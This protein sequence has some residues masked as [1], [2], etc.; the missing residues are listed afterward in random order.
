[1]VSKE[2]ETFLY[3][4]QVMHMD[5]LRTIF[6]TKCR[7]FVFVTTNNLFLASFFLSFLTKSTVICVNV[8]VRKLVSRFWYCLIVLCSN[9][10]V[11]VCIIESLLWQ[12]KGVCAVKF[13][14]WYMMCEIWWEKDIT[15]QMLVYIFS[16][17]LGVSYPDHQV[18]TNEKLVL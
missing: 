12:V 16:I 15:F 4:L 18:V 7:L 14:I 8:V 10:H 3:Y 2:K 9:H 5:N 6:C 17:H 1:M 13:K 11:Y